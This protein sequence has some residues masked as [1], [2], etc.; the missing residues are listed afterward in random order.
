MDVDTDDET[1]DDTTRDAHS[2][3]IRPAQSSS[4][5]NARTEPPKR[6]IYR[7]FSFSHASYI[8]LV[9]RRV[10]VFLRTIESTIR[11]FTIAGRQRDEDF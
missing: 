6:P 8:P 5:P 4:S 1:T 3:P 2:R 11:G 9:H 10:R 7:V